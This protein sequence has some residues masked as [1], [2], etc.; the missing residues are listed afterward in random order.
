MKNKFE[1]LLLG[2]LCL[3]MALLGYGASSFAAPPRAHWSSD[4]QIQVY[5]PSFR[6]NQSLR[7]QL[8]SESPLPAVDLPLLSH[9]GDLWS[10]S[11]ESLKS[12]VELWVK[13]PLWIRISDAQ[14]RQIDL[15]SVRLTGLLDQRFADTNRETGLF[16]KNS[17]PHFRLWAP[18][19]TQVELLR[20]SGP[21]SMDPVV[22]PLR[23]ESSGFWSVQG[24]QS[25]KDQYYLYRVRVF[26][27][28]SG[29][30]ESYEVTDPASLSLSADGARSQIVDLQDPAL[31][32]ANWNQTRKPPL[33]Q[34]TD[35]V[36]Y[37]IHLR[38]YSSHPNSESSAPGQYLGLIDPQSRAFQYLRE[39]ADAG[40]THV[41]LLPT[42]DFGGVPEKTSEQQVAKIQALASGE[43]PQPQDAIGRVRHEDSY[44]WGYNPVHWMT[45]EGSYASNPDGSSRI[46]EFRQLVQALNKIGLRVVMDVVFNHTFAANN[47]PY[48]VFD[49][50]VPYYYH[51][52]NERG[53]LMNSSCC[54]D[55]AMEN[56]MVEKLMID[57]LVLYAKEYK[58]DGFRFD[59]LN[60]HPT[61]QIPRIRE[62]MDSLTPANSGIDGAKVV[63]YAEAWPFGSLEELSPGSA[64]TQLRSYGLGVGTFN[65]RMRDA[66]RGGTTDPKE[67]SDQGFATGLFWDFNHEPANRNTPIDPE[68]QRQK[69]LHL[70]D[71]VKIGMTGNLRDY[72]IRDHRNNYVRGA[73]LFFRNT[74]TGYAAEPSESISYVSAHDGYALW[75][76][77]QA[78]L[79]FEVATRS[80]HTASA[81]DRVRVQRLLLATAA[82]SQGMPFFEGGSELLRSKSGDADSYD[83]G[84]HFNHIDLSLS[85]NNWAVGLPP[86]WKNLND[87]SFW[88]PRL[89]SPHLQVSPEQIR[90]SK[91][92]FLAL[93]RLRKSCPLLRLSTATEIRQLISLPVDQ[94]TGEDLPGL[95][96]VWIR[97]TSPRIDLTRKSILVFI[98]AAGE[99]QEFTNTQLKD[100]VWRFPREFGPAVDP[101]LAEAQWFSAEGR[102]IIPARSALV[103][104]EPR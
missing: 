27:P 70:G 53:D 76:S 42:Q 93:L 97:D 39:L 96:A 92:Y 44:N 63:L 71:V 37:E 89:L 32:P 21:Q 24:E 49:R 17:R 11:I 62:A 48:S 103:L 54:A 91:N 47:E 7:F 99:D 34:V 83:S 88:S 73:D 81:E 69:L 4:K 80:P 45:P 35:S 25:W 50:I 77:V 12:E 84:D 90:A 3:T 16:W 94:K 101:Q 86:A 102:F 18:T 58:V 75:D 41:H 38:D 15:T 36:F 65:D 40:L 67:K 85:S 82:L 78:K 14:D 2:Q 46:L 31:M 74:P 20:F 98:N 104:E 61:S 64:F 95:V 9:R 26:S 59:L 13:R 60:L 23:E 28:L 43:S 8:L 56:R 55:V 52:Y 68:G 19:A 79:P 33:A 1:F 29:Q 87:W 5:F 10:L 57:S 51:R 100:R 30:M 72:A 66:L 6:P 22:I